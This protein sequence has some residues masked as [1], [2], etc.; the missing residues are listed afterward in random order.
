[1]AAPDDRRRLPSMN[2]CGVCEVCVGVVAEV[3]D[4]ASHPP[5]QPLEVVDRPTSEYFTFTQS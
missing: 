4:L 3:H 5:G 1:M 2:E